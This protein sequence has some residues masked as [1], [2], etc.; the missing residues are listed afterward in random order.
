MF[1]GHIRAREANLGEFGQ[2]VELVQ[3]ISVEMLRSKLRY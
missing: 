3:R 1:H 2:S